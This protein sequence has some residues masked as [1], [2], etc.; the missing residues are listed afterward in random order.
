MPLGLVALVLMP[1]G[2]EKLAL[3]PMGWGIE[4]IL[5]I[6]RTVSAWPAATMAVPHMPAWAFACSAWD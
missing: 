2:L 4:G 1:L 6:G 5:W 3:V